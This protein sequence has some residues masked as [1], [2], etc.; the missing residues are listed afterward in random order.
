MDSSKAAFERF[1]KWKKLMTV[2]NVTVDTHS[3]IPGTFRKQQ[4]FFVDA[5]EQVVAFVV[6]LMIHRPPSSTLFPTLLASDLFYDP[7]RHV[8]GEQW[9]KFIKDFVNPTPLPT[10]N[11]AGYIDH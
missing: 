5:E 2:L 4:I 1:C 10:V 9:I 11:T 3:A 8:Y 7:H 6:F